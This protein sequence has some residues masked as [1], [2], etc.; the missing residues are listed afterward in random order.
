M[1]SQ[2]YQ[3]LW[4][5]HDQSALQGSVACPWPVSLTGL[6][7]LPIARQPYRFLGPVNL[8]GSVEVPNVITHVDR[9]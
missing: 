1:A 8:A 5:A 6:R 9:Y 4:L 7:G 3:V 2:P